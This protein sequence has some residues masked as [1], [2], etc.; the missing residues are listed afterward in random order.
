MMTDRIAGSREM[1]AALRDHFQKIYGSQDDL[2]VYFA[3]GRVNLIGEHTDYNGGHVF[4][5]ALTIGTYA[6][7]RI[8]TDRRFRFFSVNLPGD[9]AEEYSLDEIRSGP[10]PPDSRWT[11]YPRGII[12][13]FCQRGMVPDRG[14]DMLFYGNLPAGAGL[15]SSASLE[16]LTGFILRDCFGFP[17]DN[18]TLALIGQYSENHYNGVS[19]GIMDQFA[20]AMG[21]KDHAIFLNTSD[22][23]CEYVP[24]RLE[25]ESLII[26]NSNKKH[27]LASS[28]YNDRRRECE[29]ALKELQTVTDIQSLGDLTMEEFREYQHVLSDPVLVRRARHAVSENQRTIQAVQ[30]LKKQDVAGFGRLMKEAHLSV[31]RDYE[32]TGPELDALAEEAW[33]VPGCIGSRMTGG[34]FGGCTVSIVRDS[35][36]PRF[37]E[38]VGAAYHQRTGLDADFYTVHIGGGPRRL[39]EEPAGRGPAAQE[40]AGKEQGGKR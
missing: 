16:V 21:K 23:T 34:G 20:V 29:Q 24:L 10:V 12:H 40:P 31:S 32:V 38:Q 28:A 7:V 35:A 26:T 8:R 3:P 30:L 14:L 15:S 25:K 37:I 5:C 4:P 27:S 19:C 2:R 18:Q 36:I 22:L 9:G 39:D 1:Q 17:A 6:A 33:N 11:S 13:T